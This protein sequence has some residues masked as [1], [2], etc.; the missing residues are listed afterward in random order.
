MMIAMTSQ[1]GRGSPFLC[2]PVRS[3]SSICS[4]DSI[5]GDG[6]GALGL[7]REDGGR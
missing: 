1:G 3:G 4:S 5:S 6:V 7:G 2:S